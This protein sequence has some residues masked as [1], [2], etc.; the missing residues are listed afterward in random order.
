MAVYQRSYRPLRRALDGRLVALPRSPALRLRDGV[1]DASFSRSSS[2]CASWCPSWALIVIYLHHNLNVL[3]LPAG[4]AER[5]QG[6][7]LDR[8]A[9]SS[10]AHVVPERRV[11]HPGPPGRAEPDLARPAQQRPAALP[12]RGRSRAASTCWASCRCWS[13]LLSSITWVPG[14]LLFLLPGLRREPAGW[15]RTWARRRDPG[16]ELGLDPLPV[17]AH[18]GDL[19]LGE[20][21]AAGPRGDVRP[22]LR[23]AWA[24]P[25][26]STRCSIPGG[27]P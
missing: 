17:A 23:R 9:A 13:I 24:S 20:V 14:I 27:E 6:I 16:R 19:G 25:A 4:A 2:R 26:R 12:R 11:V 21:E 7:L 22:L 15:C 1:Q 3:E 10:W 5:A 18:A 8:P